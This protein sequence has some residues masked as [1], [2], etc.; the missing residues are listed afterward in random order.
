[1]LA[2]LRH[3]S[4][5]RLVRAPNVDAAK[6]YDALIEGRFARRAAFSGLT[7]GGVDDAESTTRGDENVRT[8][9]ASKSITVWYSFTL[10]T[11]PS[12]YCECA[13]RSPAVYFNM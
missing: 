10:L 13:T 6:P 12:P 1:V 2:A 11:V 8:P 5:R 4:L 7:G 9:C 3:W